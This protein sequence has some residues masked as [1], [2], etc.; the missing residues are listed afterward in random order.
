MTRNIK[1]QN[2]DIRED[3]FRLSLDSIQ[4]WHVDICQLSATFYQHLLTSLSPDERERAAS[5]KFEEDQSVFVI[6][7]G[8]LRHLLAAYLKQ[9]P[10]NIDFTYNVYGKPLLI[11]PKQD[12]PIYFNLSHSNDM[13]V[14]AFSLK[15]FVGI[16]I[17]YLKA[18]IVEPGV[19]QQVLSE[20]EQKVFYRKPI[21]KQPLSFFRIW[22]CKESLIKAL[23]HGFSYSP[24]KIELDISK[25]PISLSKEGQDKPFAQKWL[26][27]EFSLTCGYV[28]A[29]ALKTRQHKGLTHSWVTK[30]LFY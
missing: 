10:S 15:K 21:E 27:K 19:V 9:S 20:K 4:L 2:K 24:I 5:F 6:A 7:R 23:G 17:E 26:L 30:D 29:V 8:I 14:Y 12:N 22:V 11:Q 25:D 18:D 13:V 3:I 16:D 1:T 28:G